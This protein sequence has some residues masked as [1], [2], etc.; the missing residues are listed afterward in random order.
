VENCDA[1]PDSAPT[2]VKL[3]NCRIQGLAQIEEDRLR[4]DLLVRQVADKPANRKLTPNHPNGPVFGKFNSQLT[5]AAQNT[6]PAEFS[7]NSSSSG[8]GIGKR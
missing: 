6:H 8:R 7:T 4:F 2:A 1:D 5:G 3:F